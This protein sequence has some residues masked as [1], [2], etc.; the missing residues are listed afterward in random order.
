MFPVR[1][2]PTVSQLSGCLMGPQRI[3]IIQVAAGV[4]ER[5]GRY[6]ICQRRDGDTFGGYWEFPGGKRHPGE[7]WEACLRRELLEE[8]GVR[9]RPTAFVGSFRHRDAHRRLFLRVFRCAIVEG[10]LRALYPQALRW[11]L[12]GAL[13]RYRFPPANRPLIAQLSR[14]LNR[15]GRNG[16]MDV[17]RSAG[18]EV[19]R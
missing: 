12:P 15:T 18:R 1:A 17:R 2:A 4:I 5:S 3:E 8:L 7:R 14:R 10:R 13:R 9:V 19:R 6:L 11:V 16:T